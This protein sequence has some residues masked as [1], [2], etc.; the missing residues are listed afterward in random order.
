MGTMAYVRDMV[1]IPEV[2]LALALAQLSHYRPGFLFGSA[3]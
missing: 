3:F 2:L 1:V